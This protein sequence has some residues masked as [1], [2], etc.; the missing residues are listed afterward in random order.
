METTALTRIEGMSKGTTAVGT[1]K[2][3][4]RLLQNPSYV[5]IAERY[6]DFSFL[7]MARFR[8]AEMQFHCRPE[9]RARRRR[10]RLNADRCGLNMCVGSTD[11]T[12]RRL[13][14]H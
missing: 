2:S 5:E 6:I 4:V 8:A 13:P 11:R 7:V 12:A 3:G 10:G 14:L 9:G 1:T